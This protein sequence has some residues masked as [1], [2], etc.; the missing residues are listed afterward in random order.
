[1]QEREEEPADL[2]ASDDLFE[3][4]DRFDLDQWNEDIGYLKI[5]KT[6]IARVPV[7]SLDG[8][9]VESLR[10]ARVAPE[11]SAKAK[12]LAEVALVRIAIRETIAA[13]LIEL[14]KESKE[15]TANTIEGS[16]IAAVAQRPERLKALLYLLIADEQLSFVKKK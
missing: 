10:I 9:A 12:S 1:L 16:F 6:W 3:C 11:R 14:R 7:D 4:L 15:N 13:V 5:A 8:I 2:S